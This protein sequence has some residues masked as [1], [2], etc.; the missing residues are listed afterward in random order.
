MVVVRKR[1]PKSNL[2]IACPFVVAGARLNGI[3]I[4]VSGIVS[5]TVARDLWTGWLDIANARH[6]VHLGRWCAD[7][8]SACCSARR[9]KRDPV[10]L[11][12]LR[13]DTSTWEVAL[14]HCL[15]KNEIA[16][17]APGF[18]IATPLPAWLAALPSAPPEGHTPQ[19]E[20]MLAPAD[21]RRSGDSDLKDETAERDPG[22]PTE[23]TLPAWLATVPAAPL[24]EE[25]TPLSEHALAP[26][27]AVADDR[28]SIDNDL[29][30]LPSEWSGLLAGVPGSGATLFTADFFRA[31]GA[32]DLE[33]WGRGRGLSDDVDAFGMPIAN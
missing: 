24:Q 32:M 26:A 21:D 18:P 2:K 6:S 5:P 15:A 17:L 11:E 7:S 22:F 30:L 16:E 29:D 12:L 3:P 19:S 14:F 25:H 33:A 9:R 10:V 4:A 27:D 28:R 20:D 13:E 1:G 31:E 23:T 8:V